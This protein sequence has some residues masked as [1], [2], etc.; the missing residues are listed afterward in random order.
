MK[1]IKRSYL[2]EL[3]LGSNTPSNGQNI[4]FQDYPQLRNIFVSGVLVAD[5][6]TATISPAGKPVVS[7]LTGITLTMVD[8][9]NREIIRQ[10]PLKDIAP[11]Y[12]YGFY[13]DFE[14]FPIQL[15]K[16]YITI[17][18][19]IGLNANESV[20]INIS[21]LLPE[22]LKQAAPKTINRRL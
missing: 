17:L 1:A 3:N 5:I 19:N 22:D 11:Y 18:N 14:P 12:T 10:H 9:M 16:S 20:L 2:V 8:T 6:N 13:R 21:Y 4:Y 15:T 7:S